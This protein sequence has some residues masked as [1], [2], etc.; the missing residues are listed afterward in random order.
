LDVT[1]PLKPGQKLKVRA[2]GDGTT[3]A[4]VRKLRYKVRRGDSLYQ[5]ASKFDLKI[6]DILAW[7]KLNKKNYL[8]PG[9]R[10]TLFV[11]V[12]KI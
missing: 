5:I 12:L 2:G 6:S 7:N 11:D 1:S 3:T 8:Q 4:S 9:Q 10:L